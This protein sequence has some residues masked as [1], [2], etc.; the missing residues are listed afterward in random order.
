MSLPTA[1]KI[2]ETRAVTK[3]FPGKKTLFGTASFVSAVNE[4]SLEIRR[5]ETFSIV[6]ESG[7]GKSTLARLLVRL[8]HP[9]DGAVLYEGNDISTLS[10]TDMRRLRKDL[11]FVFQDPFSS[12]NPR[13]TVGALI[14][15]P[16]KVHTRL[17]R[18]ERRRK[19]AELLG[20]VGLRA[21]FAN[22]Y[23][24]E[25]S[26]GQRQRIGIARALASGPK[27]IVGDEPVSALDVSVQA[28]VINLL[29]DLKAEFDL[30][31]ILIAHDLA[32]IRHMSDRI[33]V[34]YLGEVVELAGNDDLFDRPLHPYTRALM[35]AIPI[36]S[37]HGR[38]M[39]ATLTGDVPSPLD[40]PS[41]CRFHPRCPHATD[42]CVSEKPVLGQAGGDRTVACHHWKEIADTAES[43]VREPPRSDTAAKR[44][45]LFRERSQQQ[46]PTTAGNI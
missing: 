9:S 26:G 1:K 23:P 11:Q 28:Q 42:L 29:E 21:A 32:V 8:L 16:M 39:N 24:H 14:E 20:K 34:M 41:G 19:V 36:A 44:F 38:S 17:T 25:F 40:P 15:E 4:V 31:L 35:R 13:M 37:P 27:V 7:C 3:R 22:R 45:A 46:E 18:A 43:A 12:L 30:T 2:I 10:E 5:G 6:G 33:A